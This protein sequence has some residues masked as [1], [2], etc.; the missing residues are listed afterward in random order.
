MPRSFELPSSI[1]ALAR[2]NALEIT[3]NHFTD[4]LQ[5]LITSIDR[6]GHEAEQRAL[7]DAEE[8]TRR[9]EQEQALRA[10]EPWPMPRTTVRPLRRDQLGGLI[11]EYLHVA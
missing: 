2:R 6:I 8:R 3:P 10:T 7:R 4:D 11:H 5:R 1:D 9:E